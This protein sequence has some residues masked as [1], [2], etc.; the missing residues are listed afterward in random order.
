MLK[1]KKN[2]IKEN[3]E[4]DEKKNEN[5][6]QENNKIKL[7]KVF[8]SHLRP[9]FHSDICIIYSTT[10]MVTHKM[11]MNHISFAQYDYY[12][13]KIKYILSSLSISILARRIELLL[14]LV[15][16][17]SPLSN[18]PILS[19]TLS[20]IKSI[21]LFLSIVKQNKVYECWKGTNNTRI[22]IAG[23]L[24]D[25]GVFVLPLHWNQVNDSWMNGFVKTM[26]WRKPINWHPNL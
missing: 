17:L 19:Y 7:W 18:S 25:C 15:L 12:R 22:M 4:Q 9:T 21:Y 5:A 2:K 11:P 23:E 8:Y 16:L 1:I 6:V 3:N 26:R 14:L 20:Y 10:V 24:I 13:Y